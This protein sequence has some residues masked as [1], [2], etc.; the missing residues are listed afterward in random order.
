MYMYVHVVG[1]ALRKRGRESSSEENNRKKKER[2][3][4]RGV[5]ERGND[6]ENVSKA[7]MR[8]REERERETENETA[9]E[10]ESCD[11]VDSSTTTSGLTTQQ[12][13]HT[14]NNSHMLRTVT[15]MLQCQ[16]NCTLSLM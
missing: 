11:L 12:L 4:R 2:G 14:V 1:A 8:N 10:E 5:S 6:L 13:Y 3:G 9:A 15:C 16:T 7:L